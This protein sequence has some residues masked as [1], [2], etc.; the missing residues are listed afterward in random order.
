MKRVVMR[1]SGL[2]VEF[3]NSRSAPAAAAWANVHPAL[4][5]ISAHT[6]DQGGN[7]GVG[8]VRLLTQGG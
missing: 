1:S 5:D 7:K 6:G 4:D 3:H 8:L 2:L